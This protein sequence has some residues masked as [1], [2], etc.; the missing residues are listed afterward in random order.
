MQQVTGSDGII[1]RE[2]G[3]VAD[4][5]THTREHNTYTQQTTRIGHW[6]FSLVKQYVWS[7]NWYGQLGF[8][9]S[10]RWDDGLRCDR[11]LDVP[12]SFTGLEWFYTWLKLLLTA[13]FPIRDRQACRTHQSP[14][15]CSAPDRHDHRGIWC[16]EMTKIGPWLHRDFWRDNSF[17]NVESLR[18]K[19]CVCVCV[20]ARV[21]VCVVVVCVCGGG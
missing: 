12:A 15:L 17:I 6:V 11:A 8:Y 13:G 14:W 1:S 2:F 5:P 20:C 16:R 4:T 9:L 10:W 19:V 21:C 7:M 3:L 18:F